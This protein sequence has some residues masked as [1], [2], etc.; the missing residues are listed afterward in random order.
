MTWTKFEKYA[1]YK[2]STAIFFRCLHY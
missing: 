2:D 1:K